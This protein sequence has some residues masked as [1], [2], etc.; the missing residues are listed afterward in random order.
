MFKQKKII[1]LSTFKKKVNKAKITLVIEKLADD[2]ADEGW[3]NLDLCNVRVEAPGMDLYFHAVISRKD[4][5]EKKWFDAEWERWIKDPFYDV[6]S[7]RRESKCDFLVYDDFVGI[8]D[9]LE[10]GEP[11][12]PNIIKKATVNLARE[13][14]LQI[15]K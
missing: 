11:L 1:Q 4:V 9:V 12:I 10:W 8:M 2:D 3:A 15:Q 6:E 14:V 5:N 7:V 13:W